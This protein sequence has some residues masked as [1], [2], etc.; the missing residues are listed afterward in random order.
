MAGK[1]TEAKYTPI[2]YSISKLMGLCMLREND[3]GMS[4][5]AAGLQAQSCNRAYYNGPLVGLTGRRAG[6]YENTGLV[7]LEVNGV[8]PATTF[9]T[10]I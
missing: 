1:H 8:I 10:R 2:W 4:V 9:G 5:N 3:I 6:S 7:V